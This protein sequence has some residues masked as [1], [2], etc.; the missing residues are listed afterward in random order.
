MGLSVGVPETTFTWSWSWSQNSLVLVL[1]WS[2]TEESQ[3]ISNAR[4]ALV[5]LHHH[6]HY[7]ANWRHCCSCSSVSVFAVHLSPSMVSVGLAFWET[8]TV[9]S[10]CSVLDSTRLSFLVLFLDEGSFELFARFLLKVQRT[11][12]KHRPDE[13]FG[14]LGFLPHPFDMSK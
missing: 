13:G 7:N 6:H 3:R 10:L 12:N 14:R 2:R 8:G 5:L 4:R 11:Q 1:S 9:L